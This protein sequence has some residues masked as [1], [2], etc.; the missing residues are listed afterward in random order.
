MKRS[1]VPLLQV[2]TMM[3]CAGTAAADSAELGELRQII[4]LQSKQIQTLSARLT[5]L[6]QNRVSVQEYR[7]FDRGTIQRQDDKEVSIKWAGAPIIKNSH[8]G[9]SFD[10][11]GGVQTDIFASSSSTSGVDYG[12]GTLVRRIR[13][14]AQGKLTGRVNYK[15]QLDFNNNQADFEDMF[16][17]YSFNPSL[18]MR[19]G[20][21]EAL[22]SLD[23]EISDTKSSFLERTAYNAMTLSR[24]VGV[25]ITKTGERWGVNAGIFGDASSK[26]NPGEDEG[27]RLSARL[28]GTPWRQENNLL[29]LGVSLYNRFWPDDKA[30]FQIATAPEVSQQNKLFS[31]GKHRADQV[32][33][34]GLE[35]AL[36]SGSWLAQAEY[37]QQ[38]VDYLDL[39]DADFQAGYAQLAWLVTGESRSYSNARG[40]FGSV[41]PRSGLN[42][43]GLGALE[44][45]LRYSQMDLVDAEILGG[46]GDIWTLGV[47]W[48]PIS[49]LR[50]SANWVHFDIE[51]SWE[52]LPLGSADHRGDAVAARMQVIW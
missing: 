51:D 30:D 44:F 45:A 48:Y 52:Q 16:L 1:L 13:L 12:S 38:Q 50:F 35:T 17:E 8:R 26:A 4:V 27:W 5:E 43:N 34:I 49:Y 46:K 36:Q 7:S 39:A 24:G 31:T 41:T 23:D 28:T 22:I 29:H 9:F 21:H 18:S 20:Y 33:F 11:I 25:S 37:G 6:E 2:F 14:G 15:A 47:N 19:V 10:P 32:N 40:A 3:L 42:D